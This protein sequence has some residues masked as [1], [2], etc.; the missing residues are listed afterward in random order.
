[1]NNTIALNTLK[2]SLS[3][4]ASWLPQ[5]FLILSAEI[6]T[7]FIENMAI[8]AFSLYNNANNINETTSLQWQ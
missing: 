8:W 3:T 7:T 5:P 2:V 6:A 1:M 4:V